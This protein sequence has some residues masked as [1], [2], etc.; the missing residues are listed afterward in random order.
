MERLHR[1]IKAALKTHDNPNNWAE[2]LPLVLLG[3]R[4]AIK[5]DLYCT[6]AE[7]VYGTTLHL[8]G[9][10]FSNSQTVGTPD[11]T[12]Y[13]TRLKSSMTQLKATPTRISNRHN[14]YVSKELSTCTHV[15]VRQDSVRKPLQRPYNGPYKVLD[16]FDKCF[17]I[18]I[19][20]R[21]DT[22]SLDRLKPAHLDI[23]S[24]NLDSQEPPSL[25]APTSNPVPKPRV[26]RSD[27]HVH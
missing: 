5:Q 4:T 11:P 25:P 2:S 9:Q 12:E 23:A 21:H 18:D 15:F 16:R 19:N 6:T 10:F 7:L 22:V 13:V 3:I 14:I 26:T 8:P 17:K 27:R 20:G 1:Q 24:D